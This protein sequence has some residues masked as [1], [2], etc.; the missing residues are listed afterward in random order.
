MRAAV[1][2]GAGGPEVIAIQDVP[3]PEP[4]T[5][6]VR[7]RV[8]TAGLNRADLQQR[9]GFYPAPPGAPA[10]IPGL[11]FMGVVDALGPGVTAVKPGQRV[12]GLVGGGGQ[13]EF[14]VT[15]E[16]LLAAVPDALDDVAAAAVPEAFITAFDALFTRARLAPGERVL[17]HAA[18]SGVG[19]AAVQLARA[20]GC[21]VFATVRTPAKAERVAALGA[22][23]VVVASS[24]DF[25]QVVAQETGGE[26]VHACIDLVGAAY[27]A[28]S[29]AALAT[30][31]RLVIVGTLSGARSE[32]DLGVVLRK[33]LTVVGTTLRARPLDEK[34]AVTRLFAERVVPQLARGLI[35]P[36]VDRVFPL[37]ALADAH[38]YMASNAGFGKIVLQIARE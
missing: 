30:R 1:Y 14:L 29:L 16:R 3:R 23:R 5:E 6:Q 17:I 2:T 20:A 15:H 8:L 11:E 34:I 22:Q 18:G 37:E 19:T 28:Q 10:N 33:R 36:I 13:A 38:G 4:G 31:G 32:I 12:F 21:T 35:H 7:I 25:A 9:L 27:L 26:G 24:E